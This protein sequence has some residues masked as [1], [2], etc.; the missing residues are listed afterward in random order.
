MSEHYYKIY[1]LLLNMST[2]NTLI[3]NSEVLAQVEINTFFI[4]Y[5]TRARM[6]HISENLI[7]CF[8]SIMGLS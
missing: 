6:I 4:S 1:T 3:N 7:I 5:R 2:I 8:I